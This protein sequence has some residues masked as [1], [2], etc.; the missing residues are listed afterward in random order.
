[1]KVRANI[2]PKKKKKR[3]LNLNILGDCMAFRTQIFHLVL[4]N[5]FKT[6]AVYSS[7]IT[8]CNKDF[9]MS[10]AFKF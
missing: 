5:N 7:K 6:V 2:L 9:V 8:C 1:M 10:Y 3:Q 4:D